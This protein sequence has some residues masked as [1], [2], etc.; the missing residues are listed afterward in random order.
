MMIAVATQLNYELFI[1]A[2]EKF[3]IHI[4]GVGWMLFLVFSLRK[5]N[6]IG[7]SQV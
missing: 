5:P 2:T 4:V 1:C 6:W 7:I 3:K